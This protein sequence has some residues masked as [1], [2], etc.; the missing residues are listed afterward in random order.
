MSDERALRGCSHR[1][2]FAHPLRHSPAA[3]HT[4]T[5]VPLCHPRQRFL[6]FTNAPFPSLPQRPIYFTSPTP[7]SLHFPNAPELPLS[8]RADHPRRYPFRRPP[9][10]QPR[11]RRR[12]DGDAHKAAADLFRRRDPAQVVGGARGGGSPTDLSGEEAFDSAAV[13]NSGG[14]AVWVGLRRGSCLGSHG[15]NDW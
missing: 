8:I 7:H 5:L 10:T 11:R 9:P 3:P 15:G 14:P 6:P 1:R 13:L 2:T 12:D 4:A